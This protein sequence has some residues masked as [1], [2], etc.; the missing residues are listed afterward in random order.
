MVIFTLLG[1][2]DSFGKTLF[3]HNLIV[4]IN[5]RAEPSLQ[6]G[7]SATF[8]PSSGDS[9]Y[10]GSATS[11]YRISLPKQLQVFLY[12]LHSTV[13]YFIFKDPN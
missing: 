7:G 8:A 11:L 9:I 12:F 2:Q 13:F 3:I 6:D 5:L 10:L 1:D 4:L